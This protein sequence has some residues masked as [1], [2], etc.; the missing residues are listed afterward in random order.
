MDWFPIFIRLRGEHTLVV[1]GGPVALRKA[2]QLL[3]ASAIVTVVAPLPCAGM[4]TLISSGLAGLIR[5]PFE[6]AMMTGHRLAIA[7]TD[8]REVNRAVAAAAQA[9]RIPV[10][11]VDDPELCSY[12]TPAILD[13]D[14]VTVAIATAGAAPILAREIRARIDAALP[15]GLGQLAGLAARWRGMVRRTL[16]SATVRR[17]FW[18]TIMRGPVAAAAMRGDRERAAGLMARAIASAAVGDLKPQ[19]EVYLVGAGPG[20][21]DLLTLK[22]LRLMNECEVV[23]HDSLVAPEILTM[24]RREAELIDVGK[25]CGGHGVQQEQINSLMVELAR[26]GKR[27]LRLKGGDPMLFG[28]AGEEIEALARAGISYQIVPGITA[29]AGC[30]A[31]TGIPLTHRDYAHTC[32]LTTG[33]T[34]DGAPDWS[35]MTAPGQ[36]LVLYMSL[37]R[38]AIN[39]DELIRHGLDPATPA[40]IISR[41]TMADLTVLTG[42]VASLPEIVERHRPKAPAVVIIGEVVGFRERMAGLAAI[43]RGEAAIAGGE[44]AFETPFRWIEPPPFPV[45]L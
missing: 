17:R 18:E 39:C 12:I 10:N 36:T 33:H 14:G 30:A 8:N 43:A 44:S 26:A 35:Q 1:G 42:T 38:V 4:E 40:V 41:G 7:A 5:E 20:D 37:G 15:R 22:A 32:V 6:A 29:A 19:G 9:C 23:L 31:A 2:K 24:V 34:R 3:S 11:V 16:P 21:P 28:R 27:V 13:R 25:R 45:H